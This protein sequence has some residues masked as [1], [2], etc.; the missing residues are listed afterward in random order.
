LT[1]R[2]TVAATSLISSFF[3]FSRNSGASMKREKKRKRE[4]ERKVARVER[5]RERERE[6][7]KEIKE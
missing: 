1:K 4:R 5:E 2:D 7:R 3:L 6:E